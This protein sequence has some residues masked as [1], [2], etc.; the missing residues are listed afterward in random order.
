VKSSSRSVKHRPDTGGLDSARRALKSLAAH[1]DA[2][3]PGNKIRRPMHTSPPREKF[4]KMASNDSL[5]SDV[6]PPLPLLTPSK[7]FTYEESLL[8]DYFDYLKR[9]D[10]STG[11]ARH[12]SYES[13]SYAS[14]GLLREKSERRGPIMEDSYTVRT[15]PLNKRKEKTTKRSRSKKERKGES[16]NAKGSYAQI[17]FLED[18]IAEVIFS[19]VRK[20]EELASYAQLC[21]EDGTA[22]VSY[23]S[24]YT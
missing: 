6:I 7:T 24:C 12:L 1:L 17:F 13:R 23:T 9:R 3:R 22:E 8:E 21:F 16:S 20:E 4:L 15:E 14:D 5:S 19:R 10:H 11:R 2:V 18:G